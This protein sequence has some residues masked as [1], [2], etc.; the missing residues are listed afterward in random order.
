MSKYTIGRAIGRSIFKSAIN[1]NF[2]RTTWTGRAFKRVK[3]GG[4]S[5]V[6]NSVRGNFGTSGGNLD[7]DLWEEA[8]TEVIESQEAKA[9][10]AGQVTLIVDYF[11]DPAKRYC[12]T[13]GK[14]Y[15]PEQFVTMVRLDMGDD[16]YGGISIII[17]ECAEELIEAL[18]ASISNDGIGEKLFG[19]SSFMSTNSR[20]FG[21]MNSAMANYSAAAIRNGYRSPTSA[22]NRAF[23][24]EKN[25]QSLIARFGTGRTK[26]WTSTGS[27]LGGNY[28]AYKQA[29][30]RNGRKL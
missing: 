30:A 14:D 20:V 4:L 2:K 8:Y 6:V 21:N 5:D 9:G 12:E 13:Y 17:D 3:S 24:L 15:D 22:A 27:Q 23:N 18:D 7:R 16:Y 29:A 26:A 11:A 19:L 25:R 1:H 28:A 10:N